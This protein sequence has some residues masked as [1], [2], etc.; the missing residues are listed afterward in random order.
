MSRYE[1]MAGLAAAQDYFGL[2]SNQRMVKDEVLFQAER[3]PYDVIL[4][5]AEMMGFPGVER[6][7]KQ[8]QDVP[9]DARLLPAY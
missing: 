4:E 9:E 8:E 2:R 3:D 6:R 7:E 5:A 1:S